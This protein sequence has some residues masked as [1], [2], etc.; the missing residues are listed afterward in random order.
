M[1]CNSS[2]SSKS[3]LTGFFSASG[4]FTF[5]GAASFL[6]SAATVSV[7]AASVAGLI[8]RL[9]LGFSSSFYQIL[10]R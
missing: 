8:I 2:S 7:A 4:F 1:G 10:F 9:R 5:T 3:F 6:G